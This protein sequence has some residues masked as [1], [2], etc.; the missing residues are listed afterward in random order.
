[1]NFVGVHLKLGNRG[2]D[3]LLY[4]KT[5]QYSEKSQNQ[6]TILLYLIVL[7]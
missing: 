4:F 1:M 7:T 2:S 3:H 6:P 5:I